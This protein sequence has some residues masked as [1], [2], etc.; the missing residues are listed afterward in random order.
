MFIAD[1]HLAVKTFL[2]SSNIMQYIP[3]VALLIV[4]ALF[5]TFVLALPLQVAPGSQYD[6]EAREFNIGL[7]ARGLY[8]LEARD[9]PTLDARD[10]EV[11]DPDSEAREYLET[12]G[13]HYQ[14]EKKESKS[15]V[16]PL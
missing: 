15:T 12:R 6:L 9:E 16:I 7:S 10:L 2:L 5:G 13:G 14:K 11:L 4:L 1:F 8:D 3:K